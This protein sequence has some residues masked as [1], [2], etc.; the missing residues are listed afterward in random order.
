MSKAISSVRHITW[1]VP[2]SKQ[3]LRDERSATDCLSHGTVIKNPLNSIN[4][5]LV[6][7]S[8]HT[9]SVL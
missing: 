8:E 7:R 6:P 9:P 2:G 5:Q 1:T 3:N 4:L